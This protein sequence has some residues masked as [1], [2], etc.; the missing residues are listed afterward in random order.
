MDQLE[1]AQVLE[2]FVEDRGGP[3]DWDS[4]ITGMRFKDP[5]LRSVQVRMSGLPNEFPP[6][7]K[8]H[9]CGPEG[10]ELIRAYIEEL[11]ASESK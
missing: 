4:Y 3:W 6:R 1:V 10:V 9:Y 7:V 8:G 5:Y 2:N 11:R